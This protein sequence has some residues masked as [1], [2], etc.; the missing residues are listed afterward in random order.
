MHSWLITLFLFLYLVLE[1]IASFSFNIKIKMI[2]KKK[3]NKA[4]FLGALSTV[5]FTFVTSLASIVAAIGG[6][7]NNGS[8]WWFIFAAAGMMAIG[9][10]LASILMIY[11]NRWW[12]SRNDQTSNE[13]GV[14]N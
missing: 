1:F 6:G 13:K 14:D 12:I 2:D 3:Y 11:F 7:S 10:I 4:A 5:I 8:M 9:N